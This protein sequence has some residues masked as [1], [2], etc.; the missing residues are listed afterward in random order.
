MKLF[1]L[2]I[3]AF[4]F[5]NTWA[6]IDP[7]YS[8]YNTSG[9]YTVQ[10]DSSYSTNPKFMIYKPIGSS[11]SLPVMIFHPGANGFFQSAINVHSYDLYTKHLASWGYVVL[12]LDI[13]TG[14]F[15]SSTNFNSAVNW[16]YTNSR[17][18]QH[19]MHTT[20]DTN[21]IIIGGH[22]NGGIHAS[23]YIAAYPNKV[24]GM[25]LFASYPSTFPPTNVGVF[26][27]KLLDLAGS[28]DDASTPAQC[29]TGYDSFTGT[30][31]K[32]FVIVE[33]LHHGGFGNYV[34]TAQPVGS[35]GRDSATATV[36][37]LL[38]SFLEGQFK[39]NN[40]ALDN[41]FDSNLRPNN[42]STFLSSCVNTATRN[43]EKEVPI[44][45]LQYH[46]VQSNHNKTEVFALDG[47][48]LLQ[49]NELSINLEAYKNNIVLIRVYN[50]NGLY[51]AKLWIE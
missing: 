17:N 22:S 19:W 13:T 16:V 48:K 28:E 11:G 42:Y 33:G 41:F 18:S 12:V 29:R 15:P 8:V 4:V 7:R 31:C 39:N 37:H 14:G 10:V 32:S 40:F 26:N 1:L 44:K 24:Q 46:L 38:L 50:N 5:I 36:R 21:R 20:A 45:L 30:T 49:S 3:L 25:V 23:S 2:T 27:G 51:Q 6:Q 34:N 9:P 35:M 43:L 47:R